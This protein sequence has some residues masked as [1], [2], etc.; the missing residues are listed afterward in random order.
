[1]ITEKIKA[2]TVLIDLNLESSKTHT[3]EVLPRGIADEFREAD[4]H[5]R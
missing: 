3:P 2:Q 1:M 5:L 4:R